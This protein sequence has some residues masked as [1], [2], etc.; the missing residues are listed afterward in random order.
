MHLKPIVN[1]TISKRFYSGMKNFLGLVETLEYN[2]LLEN[3]HNYKNFLPYFIKL[4]TIC[5]ELRSSPQTPQDCMPRTLFKI[6]AI[7]HI[8]ENPHIHST[9]EI[10]KAL[11]LSIHTPHKYSPYHYSGHY[12]CS[13]DFLMEADSLTIQKSRTHQWRYHLNSGK[14]Y[15]KQREIRLMNFQCKVNHREL[16]QFYPDMD[17]MGSSS[18]NVGLISFF[19]IPILDQ[20]PKSDEVRALLTRRMRQVS[21]NYTLRRRFQDAAYRYLRRTSDVG[22]T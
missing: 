2:I 20:C 10:L 11:N 7:S 12:H 17:D 19:L 22:N 3:G 18:W 1:F 8:G 15:R 16:P 21:L 13:R 9:L 5:S 6:I 14:I 4:R